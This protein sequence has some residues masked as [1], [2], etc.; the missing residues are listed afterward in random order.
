MKLYEYYSPDDLDISQLTARFLG[1]DIEEAE[2]VED[3]QE[4]WQTAELSDFFNE[5]YHD[6][7]PGALAEEVHKFVRLVAHPYR[8]C[9]DKPAKSPK[10][11]EIESAIK[12]KGTPGCCTFK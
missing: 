1:I 10:N 3:A 4:R 6:A 12:N 5:S 11:A 9:F 8:R 7:F 2:V